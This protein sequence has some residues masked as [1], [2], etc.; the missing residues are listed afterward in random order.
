MI[1]SSGGDLA[2]WQAE[3]EATETYPGC[4]T[5]P[6]LD[7]HLLSVISSV[8]LVQG[9]L[10]QYVA[11]QCHSLSLF[12]HL[13]NPLPHH[14]MDWGDSDSFTQTH[15]TREHDEYSYRI[16]SPRAAGQREA[17]KQMHIC[18]HIV[19]SE[20]THLTFTWLNTLLQDAQTPLVN[21]ACINLDIDADIARGC[22]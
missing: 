4:P 15:N 12:L 2:S 18:A 9:D 14:S 7:T 8:S 13:H 5:L 3:T 11:C 1:G 19:F 16:L 17:E 21:S 6:Q 10:Q 20:H 22:V